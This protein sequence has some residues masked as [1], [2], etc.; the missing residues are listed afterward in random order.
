[1]LEYT[2]FELT[3]SITGGPGQVGRGLA[4]WC[5]RDLHPVWMRDGGDEVEALSINIFLKKIT[6]RCCVAYRCQ[7]SA[8]NEKKIKY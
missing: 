6:I 1:M 2:I 8:L 3:R 7:E 5:L 4:L